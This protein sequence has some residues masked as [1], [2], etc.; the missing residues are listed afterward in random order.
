MAGGASSQNDDDGEMITEI[1]VTP[2]VDIMLVLLIIFMV[3]AS[4]IVSPSMK[5][6]LPKGAGSAAA[7]KEPDIT[8]VV[9]RTGALEYKQKPVSGDQLLGELRKE[10]KAHPGARILV[11]ADTKAYH[12]SVVKVMSIARSVGFTRLGVATEGAQ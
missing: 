10:R 7:G 9:T 5:V 2:M 4:L 3:T 8:V 1:N 6:E 12:G 11:L